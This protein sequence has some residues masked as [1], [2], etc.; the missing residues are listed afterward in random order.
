MKIRFRYI[1]LVFLILT[2]FVFGLT[3]G[4]MLDQIGRR[5][6]S[7]AIGREGELG[8]FRRI[9]Q[10]PV[11]NRVT[12]MATNPFP[13]ERRMSRNNRALV[14]QTTRMLAATTAAMPHL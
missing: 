7:L 14:R 5:R 13:Q 10:P 11:A 6:S 9:A 1:G 4:V 12:A 2:V 8:D 3:G